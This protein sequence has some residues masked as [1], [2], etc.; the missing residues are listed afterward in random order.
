MYS[1]QISWYISRI[2]KIQRN[3]MNNDEDSDNRSNVYNYV[4][5]KQL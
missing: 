3:E 4:S 2:Q 5:E 1:S